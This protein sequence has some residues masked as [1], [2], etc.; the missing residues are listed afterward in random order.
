MRWFTIIC[1]VLLLISG[2]SVSGQS[3]AG[4]SSGGA[5]CIPVKS[6][7]PDSLAYKA[8]EELSFTMHYKWGAINSDVGSAIVRL[9]TTNINGTEVFHCDVSGSTTRLFDLFFKVREQFSSWFTVG[10]L[11]PM[12]FMR[13]SHEGRYHARNRYH[14]IWNAAEPYISAE[15]SSST[16]GGRILEIPVDSCTY[17]LPALFYLARNMDFDRVEPGRKHPMKFV[18][19][20]EVFH[21]YFIMH[22]R[23]TIRVKG[24]GSVRTIRFAA[25]LVAGEVFDGEQ[26]MIIW[27]SDDLNR[28]PVFFEAP[29]LVGTARGVLTGYS[30]LKHPFSSLVK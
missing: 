5:A 19:D 20:D 11:R 2:Q 13:D 16:K 21:V 30:G 18:I 14:Y 23:E 17:D 8:G 27:I 4:Q 7:N 25:K 15:V 29:L 28:V 3:F 12:R 6:L 24:L 1:A 10:G 9:D 26:D 22:N